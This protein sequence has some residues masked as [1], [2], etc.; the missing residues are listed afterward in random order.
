MPPM[1]L[2]STFLG[3]P[4]KPVAF[5]L[6]IV[7]ITFIVANIY[8]TGVLGTSR[9][10]DVVAVLSLAAWGTLNWGWFRNAQRVAELGLLLS[11]LVLTIRAIFVLLTLGPSIQSFWLSSGVAVVAGG[12][13]LLERADPRDRGDTGDGPLTCR[14]TGYAGGRAVHSYLDVG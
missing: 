13:Y 8:N 10:G 3:R 14:T 7:M 5:G 2:S 4:I 6:S 11:T 1:N 9:W 12:S